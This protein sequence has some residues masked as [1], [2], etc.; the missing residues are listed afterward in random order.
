M[1]CS[2]RT[3]SSRSAR[4]HPPSSASRQRGAPLLDPVLG[5]VGGEVV[6]DVPQAKDPAG[7]EH[8]PDPAEGDGLPEVRKVVQGVARVHE[9][10]RLAA[11]LVGQESALDDL[12]R[13][14]PSAGLLP[15]PAE[16]DRRRVDGDDPSADLGRGEGELAGARAEIDDG[17]PLAQAH[18]L[19]EAHL[20]CRVGVLLLVVPARRARASRFSR[21]MLAISSSSQPAPLAVTP[22]SS[23]TGE[24]LDDHL[25]LRSPSCNRAMDGVPRTMCQSAAL[26]EAACTRTST[27]S[28][29]ASGSSMS[30]SCRTSSGAP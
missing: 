24:P 27:S 15:E 25:G 20:G 9:V 19:E 10:R 22:S 17:G 1:E 29:A 4:V 23:Q 3:C 26:T 2:S 6:H 8:P 12:E 16:H 28:A 14:R 21:P 5:L 13:R 7:P 18:G 11:V 30:T